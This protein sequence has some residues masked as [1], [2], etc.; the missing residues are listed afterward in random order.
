MLKFTLFK[1][2]ISVHWMFWLLA[3]FLG[4]GLQAQSAADWHKVLVFMLAVFASVIV[5]ELG[6]ALTGCKFGA[7]QAQIQLHGMG[8]VAQFGSGGLSRKQ[9]ILMTMAGPGASILLAIIFCFVAVNM[10]QGSQADSYPTFL[11]AYFV[12]V[13]VTINIFW[14]IIN[15]FP[16]LPLDGGQILRVALGPKKIK[17]TCIVSFITLAVLGTILLMKTRSIYNLMVILLLGSYTW[18]LYQQIREG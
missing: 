3:G 4:G 16:A 17:L 8:G 10:P 11:L 2:P 9:R 18:N 7:G 12:D 1:I 13:V 15:L 14:A 5:H 6:H